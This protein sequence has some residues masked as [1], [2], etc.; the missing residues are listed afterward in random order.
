MPEMP[1]E[2]PVALLDMLGRPVMHHMVELLRR[3]RVGRIAVVSETA[4]P[5]LSSAGRAV[6]AGLHWQQVKPEG[7]WRAAETAFVELVQAGADEV[8]VLRMG[9]YLALDVQDLLGFHFEKNCR[10]TTVVSPEGEPLEAFA[11]SANRRNDAA[12][13]FRHSLRETRMPSQSYVFRDYVNRLA[14]AHDFRRLAVDAMLRRIP[15]EP[16]GEEVRPGVWVAPRASIH[17]RARVVAPAF[18]GEAARIQPDAVVTR[19]GVIEHHA[20]VGEG[21]VV[22]DSTVLPAT[23]VGAALEVAHAI[24]GHGFLIHLRRKVKLETADPRWLGSVPSNPYLRVVNG[25]VSLAAFLPA[26]FVRG[27]LRPFRTAELAFPDGRDG[28]SPAELRRAEDSR[29]DSSVG[30]FAANIAVARRYGNE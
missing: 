13:L 16:S 28:A 19:C 23:R 3:Q 15:I 2:S 5:R 24:A 25:L 1:E 26:Q 29:C 11:I 8:L 10:V 27:L 20:V 14:T 17:P 18:V 6:Q 22:E 9:G 30:E 7:F 4:M 21:T 12:F